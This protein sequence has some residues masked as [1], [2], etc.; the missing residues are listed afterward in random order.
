MDAVGT[1]DGVHSFFWRFDLNHPNCLSVEDMCRLSVSLR[2]KFDT[3][4]CVEIIK[5]IVT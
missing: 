5:L 4:D 2:F 3:Q 1:Y